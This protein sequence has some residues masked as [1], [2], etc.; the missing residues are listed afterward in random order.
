MDGVAQ[1]SPEERGDLFQETAARRGIRA[2][3]IE[4]D[5]WVCWTLNQLFQLDGL[6]RLLFKG[7]TSL[8]KAFRLID[9]FSEDVDVVLNRHDI[10][11]D[12]EL[13]P[14]YPELSNT[15]RK[16]LVKKLRRKANVLIEEMVKPR[17]EAAFEGVVGQASENGVSWSLET[18]WG[19]DRTPSLRFLYPTT[20]V[21]SSGPEYIQPSV[22]LELGARGD[23]WPNTTSV[24]SPYAAEE[25]PDIFDKPSCE[26]V[27]LE[28]SRTFWEKATLLHGEY[29]LNDSAS[30]ARKSRH[31]YDVV[32]IARSEIGK[33]ALTDLELLSEVALHKQ[34]FFRSPKAKYN[35][36][37]PPTL[38]LVPS[39]DLAGA[40]KKDYQDMR[41]MFFT[42]PPS[43]ANLMEELRGL[44]DRINSRS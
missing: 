37:Q 22:L 9:R 21:T 27:T 12:G 44:E 24:L 11:F 40:L 39:D 6:P 19:T 10:G 16:K 38:R 25:F 41:D 35:E 23:H 20:N 8:S 42:A 14:A 26:I 4:K 3:I 15:R 2:A 13:D 7:G 17:L 43:F 18:E 30:C 34:I 31:Y 36:A 5:F 32:M 33:T 29:N 1:L 28:A